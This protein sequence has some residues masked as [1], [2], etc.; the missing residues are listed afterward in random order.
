MSLPSFVLP[1]I[2]DNEFGWGP[3]D[4]PPQLKDIPFAPFNKNDRLGKISDWMQQQPRGGRFPSQFGAGTGMFQYKHDD[5]ESSFSLVDN[6]PKPKNK[7]R[8]KTFVR[9]T[10][11]NWNNNYNRNGWRGRGRGGKSWQNNNRKR[12]GY[13]NYENRDFVRD[14]SV[15]LDESWPLV[16]TFE[17]TEL[18]EATGYRPAP[19]ENLV[20]CGQLEYYDG[21][22]DRISPKQPIALHRFETRQHF[23]VT[24][25][26]DPVLQRLAD[27]GVGNVYATDTI[28]AILMASPKSVNSWDLLVRKEDGN[29]FIDKRTNSKIDFL[30]VNENWNEPNSGEKDAINAAQSLAREATLINHNFSQ[31]ILMKD[32]TGVQF[33]EGN[34]F[35]SAVEKGSELASVAYRYRKWEFEG[36]KLVARCSLNG[37]C[38]RKG[39]SADNAFLVVRALNEFDSKLS[40]NVDWRQKLESQTGSVLAT[41]MKNNTNKIARWTAETVLS[42]ADEF[43]LGFVSRVNT[44]DSFR[45]SVLMTKRYDPKTFA[46]SVNIKVSQ[47]WGVL[48]HIL[49]SLRKM[50]DGHYLLMKD[51]NKTELQVYDIPSD[52]FDHEDQEPEEN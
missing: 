2:T 13:N 50:E 29:I 44:K 25:S 51:P 43:R 42:G 15:D 16:E 6:R 36:I 12:W 46:Q 1:T 39:E 52:A 17:F 30:S 10:Q 38:K 35:A 9:R 24:T 37:V 7:F 11:N 33:K 32:E 49:T 18:N 21:K 34:P 3:A 23:T 45:H 47:L 28:L 4:V 27:Q 5:D 14:P 31:Q 40:G 26:Q 48:R 41:E 8:T 20:E 19:A 22:F